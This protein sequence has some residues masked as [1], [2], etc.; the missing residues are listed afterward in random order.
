M[1]QVIKNEFRPL[2]TTEIK[3]LTVDTKEKSLTEK[4]FRKFSVVDLWVI[5]RNR[6]LASARIYI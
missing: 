3:A 6:K 5:Q 1:K 2:T 4:Q